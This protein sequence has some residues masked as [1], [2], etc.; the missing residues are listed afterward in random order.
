MC[1][2]PNAPVQSGCWDLH[3]KQQMV[4][5]GL[6]SQ[7][8]YLDKKHVEPFSSCKIPSECISVGVLASGE[9]TQG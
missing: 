4:F 1:Q 8:K 2:L 3:F 9:T 7:L 5:F 6:S